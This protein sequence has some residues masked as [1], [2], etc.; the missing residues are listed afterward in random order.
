MSNYDY[1]P[2]GQARKVAEAIELLE[3]CYAAEAKAFAECKRLHAAG[4]FEGARRALRRPRDV[5]GIKQDAAE[6]R[7][8]E[9]LSLLANP[10]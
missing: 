2:E 9:G 5:D 10:A 3:R 7:L 8:E 4:D 6:Q 1:T